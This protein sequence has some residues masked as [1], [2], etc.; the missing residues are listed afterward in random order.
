MSQP[1]LRSVLDTPM[2]D[3]DANADTIREYLITLLATV[4]D[5]GEGFSAKRPFGNSGWQWEL[6]AVLAQAGHINGTLD[7]DGYV[8]NVDIH[9]G[10]LLIRDAIR[11][12]AGPVTE[13]M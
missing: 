11:A 6:Y 13:A 5:E 4:W 3:N 12:L 9:K 10:N 8:D 7:K 2:G 1:D